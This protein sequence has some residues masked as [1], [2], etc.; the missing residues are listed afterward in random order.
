MQ[1]VEFTKKMKKDYT[2]LVP[3][4]LPVHFK[5]ISKILISYGYNVELLNTTGKHIADTGL[6]YVHNDMC[7]PALLV[8]GQLIDAVQSGKYDVHK[9]ALLITQTG[10]GCRA[11]NYIYLLRKALQ[12][13]DL[14]FIPVISFNFTGVEKSPGFNMTLSIYLKLFSAV[15]YGD[16]LMLLK[17]QTLPYEETLGE[18]MALVDS[19]AERLVSAM[20]SPSFF[21]RKTSLKNYEA[22]IKDFSAIKKPQPRKMRVGIVGEIYVKFAPLGNNNLEDFLLSEDVEIVMAGLF[23]FCMYCI[24]NVIA[25]K[26]NYGDGS[27]SKVF[28][29]KRVYNYLLD[30]QKD[31]ID[32]IKKYSTF[33]PPCG[34]THVVGLTDGYIS[35]ATKMGEGWLLPAEMLELIDQGVD[36]IVCTQPFGCLPNHI[37]GRGMMKIIKDKNPEVNL[38]AVDYDPGATK[39][40]QENRIKLMLAIGRENFQSAAV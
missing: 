31:M 32:S 17:N 5:L 29:Y 28:I 25:D 13:A 38:V 34:F 10:G 30:R 20:D 11:S 36:N 4:M 22:I 19:W 39:V 7:Y 24:Y 9:I 6:K 33:S 35:T 21:T 26:D 18:T 14:G 15:M 16:L 2:I 40:N 37:C 3:N 12:K 23:D 27:S 1:K 8:I